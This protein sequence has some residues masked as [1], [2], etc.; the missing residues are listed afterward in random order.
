[1]MISVIIAT[2]NRA[3]LLA[4]TLDALSRQQVSDFAFEIVVV[5]NA[6]TD[7]TALVV[8]AAAR[9][10]GPVVYLFESRPGKSHALNAAVSRARGDVLVFTDDDVLPSSNWLAA[11]ARVFGET[12]ADFAAGRIQ[13]LWE[14]PPPSWMS[15]AL[16]GVLAVADGG[17]HRLPIR[18][19][20]KDDIMP[21]G[22]NMA[23]RRYVLDRVG[24]WDPQFGKLQGTLRTGEDHDF[25]L[26]MIQAGFQGVFEPEANVQHRVPAERLRLGYFHR[27]F[28]DNGQV[29]AQMEERYPTTARYFLQVPRYLWREALAD[30]G[31]LLLGLVTLDAK[32]TVASVTRLAWLAGYLRYRW[33]PRR[34]QSI[35]HVD[36]RAAPLPPG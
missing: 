29:D 7:E 26:R 28:Y 14:S 17:A 36:A 10:G 2:R 30:V 12:E 23:I 15:P 8:E 33:T 32:R 19:G 16:H 11:Y 13:P 21:L 5:D 1:M 25:F 3:P 35:P 24:S 22:A 18:H 6:S 20:A 9:R 27:W 4:S 34:R 31:S